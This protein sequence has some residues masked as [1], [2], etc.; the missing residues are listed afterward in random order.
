MR[1]YFVILFFLGSLNC[2]ASNHLSLWYEHPAKEWEESLPIG[3]GRLG[4]MV[5]GG[6]DQERIQLNEKSLWS[7]APMDSDNPESLQYMPVVQQLLFDGKYHEAEKLA[8]QKLICKGEGTKHALS[9]DSFF[10]CYQTLGDL[11]LSFDISAQA[12]RYQRTLNLDKAIATVSY[13]IG[14]ACYKREIF[15]SA[16]DQ[17][18]VMR[19]SCDQPAKISFTAGLSREQCASVKAISSNVI[20]MSGQLF[21][22]KGMNYCARLHV[23]ADGG[24]VSSTESGKLLVK[25]ADEVL[26][27]FAANTDFQNKSPQSLCCEQIQSALAKSYS[28][29]QKA[30]IDDYRDLFARA[31]LRIK[32]DSGCDLLPTDVRL[33]R[34]KKGLQDP[35]LSALL[36]NYGRYLLISSSRPGTLPANLQGLWAHEIQTAWNGDYHVNINLQMNYWPAEVANLSECHEPLFDFI[37]SLRKPGARSAQVH[38]NARGWVVHWCTNIWGFTSPG[39]VLWGFFPA[40]GG[41]LCQHLWEHYAFTHDEAFL[42]RAYPVMRDSAQFYLDI[43]VEH[44]VTKQL[45]TNPS[46]SPENK[47]VAPDGSESVLCV[48][49]S[50]DQQIIWDLFSH[51]IEAAHILKIDPSFSK[52]LLHARSRLVP[53]KIGKYGQL[54][55][56]MEDFEEVNPGHRHISHLF[57]LYPGHQISLHE[58]PEL[59]RAAAVS[60]ERR[61]KHGG[62]HTSWSRAWIINFWARLEESERAY[63]NI[64]ALLSLSTLPNLFSTHP[65]FQIDGNFGAAAGIAEMLLQSHAGEISILPAI[66]KAWPTGSYSGLCARHGVEVDA[67]WEEGVLKTVVLRPKIDGRHRLRLPAG[68][69]IT[70]VLI[71]GVACDIL[72][73]DNEIDLKKDKE[74]VFI[75]SRF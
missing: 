71:D 45:V 20:E 57:A 73:A 36:F 72:D 22:G 34:I 33:D 64:C 26:L 15:S 56:W 19:I 11:T 42:Q 4:G 27:V 55:E 53:P 37:D 74:Y 75:T 68:H 21:Q 24:T 35:S 17:V 51:T 5:F 13:Q 8:W 18:I 52:E 44:P 43:L 47:F 7:G 59:A 25:D 54:Q 32:D 29:L 50:M 46:H 39:E 61:L 62:G 6:I 2:Y 67:D 38:Y 41:W 40:A 66:P 48:G 70:A 1:M 58:T 23:T 12:E 28:S 9:A 63:D 60:L 14:E 16:P 49:P 30:H 31:T 69:K 65:P 10:G 3:N